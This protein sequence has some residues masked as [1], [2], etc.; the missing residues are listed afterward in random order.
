VFAVV[1]L[2]GDE[3][4]EPLLGLV[5]RAVGDPL[6]LVLVEQTLRLRLL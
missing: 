3:A 2:L 5:V 4:E 6:Q 1:V